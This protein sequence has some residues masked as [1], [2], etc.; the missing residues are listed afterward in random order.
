MVAERILVLACG[1]LAREI[2]AIRTLNK[3][4][5]VDVRCLPARLHLVPAEIPGAVEA[6]LRAAAGEYERVFV[7]YA[8]CGTHGALDAVLSAHGAERLEGLHC[9]A[10]FAGQ[11]AWEAMQEAEPGTFYLTDF[12]ARHAEALVL[13]PL[14]L[15]RFPELVDDVFGNYR[16]VVYLAQ[17]DDPALTARAR[18]LAATLGLDFERRRTGYGELGASLAHFAEA[19]AA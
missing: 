3:W 10:T 4:A 2:L 6:K 15:D 19:R 13:R 9:Y 14:G 18:A 7:A 17:T 8:D 12:L 1:A 5:H 11:D 16:R